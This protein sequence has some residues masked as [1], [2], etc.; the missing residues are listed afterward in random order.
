MKQQ[1][2]H[3]QS[4]I[5]HKRVKVKT[6]G[7]YGMYEEERIQKVY[8]YV[9]SQSR[10]S[11][12]NLCEVFDVSESTVRRDLTELENRKLLKR[13]HGGAICLEVVG[14]EPT[15]LEKQDQEQQEKQRIAACAAK[16]IQSGDSV[17]VD[18]GT[19]TLGLAQ[20][21]CKFEKL[22]VVTN[23]I[24]L[25]QQL[26]AYSNITLVCIGGTL[27]SNTMA[28]AGPFA[29][30]N[31]SRLRVDKAFIATNGVDID[32][33][34]TTPSILEASVKTQMIQISEQVYVM[35]DH[36]KF[37]R[38]SFARF[39]TLKQIDGC[40][41]SRQVPEELQREFTHR[42]IRLIFAEDSENGPEPE[43]ADRGYSSHG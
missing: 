4:F 16:L 28:L 21:L 39:G 32:R 33:G 9:Q 43:F 13:T 17:L 22:T 36:T 11:V 34:L 14:L 25:M 6:G 5:H 7:V 10:A 19:T 31:L 41:T 8:Q 30:E 38:V 3:N 1:N 18:S 2:N 37:G 12:R 23:S 42:N 27:R 15:Y 20:Y 40:I 29:E 24:F 35:A 26:S